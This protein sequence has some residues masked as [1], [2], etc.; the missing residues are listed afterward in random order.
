MIILQSHFIRTIISDRRCRNYKSFI[1]LIREN[2]NI[3]SLHR[4]DIF[5]VISGLWIIVIA[6]WSFPW[7]ASSKAATFGRKVIL[8]SLR[9]RSSIHILGNNTISFINH[10]GAFKLLKLLVITRASIRIQ[11]AVSRSY[12]THLSSCTFFL[13]LWWTCQL[14]I[15]T[16][17]AW[18]GKSIYSSHSTRVATRPW[19]LLRFP[20]T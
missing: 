1:P 8:H 16:W 3:C 6:S 15:K 20:S 14:M 19:S 5:F 13:I 9:G 10:E 11:T 17:A 18:S 12:T 2:T 7:L 4:R